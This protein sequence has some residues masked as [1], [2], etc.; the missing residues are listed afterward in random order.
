MRSRAGYW[1]GGGLVAVGV[2]GG[3][4]WIVL[5]VIA[6]SNDIEAFQHVPVPGGA[7]LRLEARKYIMYYEGPNADELVPQFKVDITDESGEPVA[8]DPYFGS[9]T[10]SFGRDGSAQGTVTPR[11]AG[12]FAVQTD[13]GD[14]RGR[15]AFGRP[16]GRTIVRTV[17]GAIAIGG[18]LTC[19]G[20]ALLILTGLRRNRA[21]RPPPTAWPPGPGWQQPPPSW[22]PT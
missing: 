9:F 6:I 2:V 18:I 14:G 4:L 20:I 1:I 5:S 12:R 16:L 13:G 10:Y 19:A 3:V 7:T 17:L 15:V 21:R 8:I 22:P 11:H